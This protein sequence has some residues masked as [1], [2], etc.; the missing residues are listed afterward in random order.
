MTTLPLNLNLATRPLRNRRFFKTAIWGLAG[1]IAVLAGLSAFVLLKY[2]GRDRRVKAVNAEALRLQQ[3][4]RAEEQR[5][6]NLIRKAETDSKLR[7]GLA[8]SIILKKSFR[9]TELFSAL[10]KSL[11]DPSYI[12][13]LNPAFTADGSLAM[14]IR[15]TSRGR[16]DLSTFITNLVA[17]G[18]KDIKVAGELRTD[19]G[20]LIAEI[21]LRYERAL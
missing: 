5:L 13:A 20:R 2:G 17:R 14:H 18:F 8:N 1:L 16:E 3:T 15:V 19:E 12:T 4:A 21:D 7:V 6:E 11:P 9:W 10:E